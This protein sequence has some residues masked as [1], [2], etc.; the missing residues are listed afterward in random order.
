MNA[1]RV[2]IIGK[3][4]VE[5]DVWNTSVDKVEFYVDN[6][7][8]ESDTTAPYSWTWAEK[9]M[10]PPIHTLKVVGYAGDVEVGSDEVGVLYLNPFNIIP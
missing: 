5:V 9:M 2:I 10:F 8:K 7:L 4:D 1:F 6:E 3:V